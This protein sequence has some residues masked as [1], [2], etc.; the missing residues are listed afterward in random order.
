[1]VTDW[2]IRQLKT[3]FYNHKIEIYEDFKLD[4]QF[5]GMV[6]MKSGNQTKYGSTEED[7]LHQ[8]FQV[9]GIM[10]WMNKFNLNK[11]LQKKQWGLGI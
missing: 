6:A 10:Y 4:K 11:P 8:A 9:F 3:I 7:H 5:N 1:M 2:S